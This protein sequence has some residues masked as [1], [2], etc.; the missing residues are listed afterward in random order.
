MRNKR[1][2]R[3]AGVFAVALAVAVFAPGWS[4]AQSTASNKAFF[5]YNPDG[6]T[7]TP[8]GFDASLIKVA[9]AL[10]TSTNGSVL[11]GLSM[12]CVLWTNTSVTSTSGGG[13]NSASAQATVRAKIYVD[14]ILATP[15]EVVYCDRTQALGVTL[16]TG[17]LTDSVT[18]ELFQATKN[19]NHFNFFKGPLGATMHSVEVVVT[20]VVECRDNTGMVVTCSSGT[21]ANMS[22]GT[23]VGI[24][25]AVLTIQEYNNTNL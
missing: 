11:I 15:E 5:A 2:K 13:K 14:G 18:V 3:L 12:E 10:K 19:A 9:S 17:V 21:L 22:T 24:G 23:K 4:F 8:L 1:M 6:I 20:G 16:T 25:K 7:V